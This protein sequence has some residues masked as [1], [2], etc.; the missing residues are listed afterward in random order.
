M[1]SV[2]PDYPLVVVVHGN[3]HN[4]ANYV[5]LLEHLARNGFISIS[6]HIRD[7]MHGLGRA[8]AFIDHLTIVKAIFGS[9]LQNNVGVL[10]HSQAARP[11]SRSHA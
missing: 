9:K 4:Y 3:G 11:C 7:N 10:G 1:S 5:F 2:R 6:I 8:N